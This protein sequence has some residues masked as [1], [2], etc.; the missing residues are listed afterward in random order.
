MITFQV[1]FWFLDTVDYRTEVI[2]S[3]LDVLEQQLCVER[4]PDGCSDAFN[5][6][7]S[8]AMEEENYQYARKY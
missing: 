1:C 2:N 8:I 6:L 7:A 4:G 5:D 3:D